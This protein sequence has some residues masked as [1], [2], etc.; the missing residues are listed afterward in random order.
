MVTWYGGISGGIA[1]DGTNGTSSTFKAIKSA[2]VADTLDSGTDYTFSALQKSWIYDGGEWKLWYQPQ[3]R[4]NYSN[5]DGLDAVGTRE[6]FLGDAD[7]PGSQWY[8]R[9]WGAGGQGTHTSRRPG[10]GGFAEG[11]IT[12]TSESHKF[13]RGDAIHIIAGQRGHQNDGSVYS[14]GQW[15]FHASGYGNI[16]GGGGYNGN[17]RYNGGGFSGIFF[18]QYVNGNVES[19]LTPGSRIQAGYNNNYDDSVLRRN[20]MMASAIAIAGGGGGSRTGYAGNGGGSRGGPGYWSSCAAGGGT[21]LGGGAGRC[22]GG[23]TGRS[24]AGGGSRFASSSH[25]TAQLGGGGWYGGGSAERAS[26]GGSGY[27][28]NGWSGISVWDYRHLYE[29]HRTGPVPGGEMQDGNPYGRTSMYDLDGH[30]G[31]YGQ[32]ARHGLVVIQNYP[33]SDWGH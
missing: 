25:W 26:G 4:K 20:Q 32:G 2:W 19:G 3:W 8:F 22:T 14:N 29:N 16:A 13:Q 7:H 5:D 21:Q 27:D 31:T 28:R 30:Y 23:M 17:S 12:S 1:Y 18:R 33:F 10:C 9:C 6:V 11:Y 15:S 24:F